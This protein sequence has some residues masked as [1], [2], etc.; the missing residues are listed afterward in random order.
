M[1]KLEPRDFF[2]G[3]T[4][5]LLPVI[6]IVVLVGVCGEGETLGAVTTS[7]ESDLSFL[8][9]G[10]TTSGAFTLLL[11]YGKIF[12]LRSCKLWSGL[13]FSKGTHPRSI[14][15]I[16]QHSSS[17]CESFLRI[18]FLQNV[19]RHSEIVV[20]SLKSFLQIGHVMHAAILSLRTFTTRLLDIFN[21][22]HL[23]INQTPGIPLHK[24]S[25]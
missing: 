19:W 18:H 17:S 7:D 25:R 4:F 8:L 9:K 11:L 15:H 20:A 5:D 2:L 16:G 22:K 13:N 14:L 12:A 23:A 1:E 24:Y 3:V 10:T 6:V 21:T